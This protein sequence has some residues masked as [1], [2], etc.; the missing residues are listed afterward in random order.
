MEFGNQYYYE[1]TIRQ[2][3]RELLQEA[4]TARL[5][6]QANLPQKKRIAW[7]AVWFNLIA[8]WCKNRAQAFLVHKP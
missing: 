4:E 3:H 2:R 6:K 1:I 7:P 5:L 8:L